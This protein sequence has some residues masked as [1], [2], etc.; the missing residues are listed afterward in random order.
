MLSQYSNYDSDEKIFGVTKGG[1][2]GLQEFRPQPQQIVTGAGLLVSSYC[3]LIGKIIIDYTNIIQEPYSFSEEHDYLIPNN[4]KSIVSAIKAPYFRVRFRNTKTDTQG[5]LKLNTYIL[6]TNPLLTL[7]VP[8][9]FEVDTTNSLWTNIKNA[10]G[11]SIQID[12]SGN[13]RTH[14]IYTSSSTSLNFSV[15][16]NIMSSN[17]A[18]LGEYKNFDILLSITSASNVYPVILDVYVSVDGITYIKSY[19]NVTINYGDLTKGILNCVSNVPYIKLKGDY[20][21]GLS[22]SGVVYMRG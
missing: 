12:T 22:L 10:S 14:N 18:N 4:I 21:S 16:N 3:D 15:I 9:S 6:P 11:I 13:L 19:Y 8:S 5:T 1:L 20:I 2:N 17:S 7:D